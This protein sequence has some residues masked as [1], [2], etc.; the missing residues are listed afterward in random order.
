[1]CNNHY[2]ILP[3]QAYFRELIRPWKI[4]SF[5]IGMS[6][7]IYGAL[8]FEIPDWD[9]GISIL[10]GG[11]TYLCAPWSVQQIIV[12][13]R[14]RPKRWLLHILA[15]FLVAVFVVD[16][17]YMAYHSFMGNTVFREANFYAS[18][19]LYFL[20]GSIWLYRGSLRDFFWNIKS[21]NQ[22]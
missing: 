22:K 1:M 19:M 6:W 12:S 8:N 16:I 14:Y 11:L 20:C 18:L 15:A 21:M 9:V 7:L 10:M 3:D 4:L 13:L 17:A 2:A 5:S